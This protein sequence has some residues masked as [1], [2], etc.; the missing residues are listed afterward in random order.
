MSQIKQWRRMV[1]TALVLFAGTGFVNSSVAGTVNGVAADAEMVTIMTVD[2]SGKPPF[3]RRF[4]TVPVSDAAMSEP[5]LY[6]G[7]ETITVKSVDLR[8]K[9]PFKRRSIELPVSDAAAAEPAAGEQQ[10]RARR[11]NRPPFQR[12]S[13]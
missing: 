12:H 5:A 9:P 8:G 6:A 2:R 13:M 10:K 1:G 7:E 3:K 11:S 4:E